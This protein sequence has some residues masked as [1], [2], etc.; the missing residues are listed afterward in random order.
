MVIQ[1]KGHLSQDDKEGIVWGGGAKG[2][3]EKWELPGCC[4]FA[5]HEKSAA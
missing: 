3:K 5:N 2:E 1:R 4:F